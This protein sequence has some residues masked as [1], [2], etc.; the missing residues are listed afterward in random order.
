MAEVV[1]INDMLD[2]LTTLA[3]QVT[4]LTVDVRSLW[5]SAATLVGGDPGATSQYSEDTS[6][7]GAY[8]GGTGPAVRASIIDDLQ[9][10][11]NSRFKEL[12]ES[13]QNL[14]AAVAMVTENMNEQENQKKLEEQVNSLKSTVD[15]SSNRASSGF[16]SKGNTS[17]GN[18]N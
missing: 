12:E 5:P 13:N 9:D 11:Y 17:V 16:D 18:A 8:M 2:T 4:R 6:P 15:A 14:E 1:R 7:H 10:T 3:D